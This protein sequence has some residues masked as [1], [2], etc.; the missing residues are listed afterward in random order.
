MDMDMDKN[1]CP[2]FE[3][4]PSGVSLGVQNITYNP[5]HIGNPLLPNMIRV[6]PCNVT[7]NV[8]VPICKTETCLLS[9]LLYNSEVFYPNTIRVNI[10]LLNT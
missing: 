4:N 3:L 1:G 5:N 8:P 6:K 10:L 9:P 7:F 2:S